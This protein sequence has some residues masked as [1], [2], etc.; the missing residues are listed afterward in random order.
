MIEP[1]R[2]AIPAR[3]TFLAAGLCLVWPG[4]LHAGSFVAFRATFTRSTGQP[5]IVVSRFTVRNP[6]T[7]FTL[8]V[9]NGADGALAKVSSAVV[10]LNGV[11]VVGPERVQPERRAD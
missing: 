4:L 5:S 1:R 2:R 6:D 3:L 9:R 8:R 11:E 10:T 7:A